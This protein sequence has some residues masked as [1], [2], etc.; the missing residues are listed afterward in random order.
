[1]SEEKKTIEE[2]KVQRRQFTG[3]VTSAKSDKTIVVEVERSQRHKLYGK[4]FVKSRKFHVHDEQNQ[5]AEGDSVNFVECRP[6][7][8][9]KRWR[10]VTTGEKA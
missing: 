6:L 3:V 2:K 4:F 10:V 5:Y 7:S 1:M 8:K 9:T